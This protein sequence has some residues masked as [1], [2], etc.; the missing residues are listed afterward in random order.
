[1]GVDL[2]NGTAETGI[3]ERHVVD[4]GVGP[5][6]LGSVVHDFFKSRVDNVDLRSTGK[7]SHVR[8][9]SRDGVAHHLEERLVLLLLVLLSNTARSNVI[10]ILEPLKVRAGHTSTV[11]EH[12]GNNNNSFSVENL[13]GHEG[14]RTVSSFENNLALEFISVVNVDSLFLGSGNEDITV[15]LHVGLRIV[16]FD[17]VSV[18]VVSESTFLKHLG[19]NIVDIES[20][21]IVDGRVIL[22]DTY[23]DTSIFLEELCSPV[24]DSSKT[25]NDEGLSRDSL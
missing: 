21:F 18:A 16:D 19:S 24:A 14:S 12:V 3:S 11:G 20:S 5:V 9:R 6:L 22:D 25:L 10:Q 8:G 2:L 7:L 13:F 4:E 17:E 23:N 15:L 1:M